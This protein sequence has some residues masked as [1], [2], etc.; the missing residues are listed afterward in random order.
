MDP[1]EECIFRFLKWELH[2]AVSEEVFENTPKRFTD[3]FRELMGT[4]D[5]PWEFTTF[6]TDL[7]EMI[8]VSDFDFVTLCEHHL[9][10]FYGRAHVGYIPQ[11]CMAGLS[12]IARCVK[13]TARGIWTQEN[14]T[15][16]IANELELHLAPKGVAVVLVAEHTCM[17]IR[18]VKSNGSKT[19]TSAL[20]GVY[21]DNENNARA[22]FLR[23]I[24]G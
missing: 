13:S 11:G 23:L 5:E 17:G 3:A 8:V 16:G 7:D 4:H 21:R 9:L 20:R 15:V 2:E 19:T 6:E 10:P 24:H 1:S 18:G 22:E 12:K 14:L